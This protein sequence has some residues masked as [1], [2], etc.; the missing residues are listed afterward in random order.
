MKLT[1]TPAESNSSKSGFLPMRPR[2]RSLRLLRFF[3]VASAGGETAALL[4]AT[5]L[6]AVADVASKTHL[7]PVPSARTANAISDSSSLSPACTPASD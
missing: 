2:T 5:L 6:A 3:P 4:A 7:H 1:L